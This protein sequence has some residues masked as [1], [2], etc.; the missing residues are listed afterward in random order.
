MI[1]GDYTGDYESFDEAVEH[2]KSL[3]ED[4][5]GVLQDIGERKRDRA[6]VRFWVGEVVAHLQAE[7]EYG[8]NIMGRITD[9]V[10][11]SKTYLRES[12]QFYDAHDG[13]EQAC[14]AWMDQVEKERGQ[15][16]WSHCRNWARK[17][18]SG[19][20]YDEDQQTVEDETRRIERRAEKLSQDVREME[21]Q[22]MQSNA[23]E[24]TKAEALGAA[25]KA[26]QVAED[27]FR[28]SDRL[29]LDEYDTTE[30]KKWRRMVTQVQCFA[31]GKVGSR[32]DM[33]PHHLERAGQSLKVPDT[34]VGA[35]CST[36]HDRL[37]DM[38]EEEFWDSVGVNPWKQLVKEILSPALQHLDL[39]ELADRL[40]PY[41][42]TRNQ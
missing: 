4:E 35:L 15:V 32:E 33:H 42:R 25:A 31:C 16:N 23:D 13:S 2:I 9:Q 14:R 27:A 8:D 11:V 40:E 17:K 22:V 30:S 36:C 26:R 34:E 7:A 29:E 6:V 3:R 38:P 10:G 19:D 20:D 1:A 21:E 41:F 39:D 5:L 24:E 28:T 12:R 37:H 18:L